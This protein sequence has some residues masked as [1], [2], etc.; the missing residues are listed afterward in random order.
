MTETNSYNRA[1]TPRRYDRIQTSGAG[2]TARW[3]TYTGTVIRVCGESVFVRWD[4][5]HFE[6]EMNVS[7][8]RPLVT[9]QPGCP[10]AQCR[11]S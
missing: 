2:R 4:C 8:V 6:D 9:V 11:H 5:L 7:E 10:C 1:V 3:G